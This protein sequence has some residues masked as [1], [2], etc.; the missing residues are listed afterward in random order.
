M[1]RTDMLRKERELKRA[2]KKVDK[3]SRESGGDMS[4]G[5]YITELSS[6]FFHDQAKIYNI[7]SD[8]RILELLEDM[9]DNSEEKNWDSIIRKSVKKTGITEKDS[10]VEQLKSLL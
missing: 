6:L 7:D 5:D 3:I 10:A 9:K 4:V 2:Q 8:E 1:K